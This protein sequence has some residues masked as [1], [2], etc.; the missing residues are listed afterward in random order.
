[1]KIIINGCYGGF[2]VSEDIAKQC[3]VDDVFVEEDE[4][5]KN[6][7]LID[8]I[9]KGEYVDVASYS[10]L[11]VVDIPSEATDYDIIEYDGMEKVV[12]VL[13]G[14]LNYAYS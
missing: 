10:H 13:D 9:E 2:S 12:Y 3:G 11:V 1:M 8:M 14:K 6:P 4:L 7:V 5:R